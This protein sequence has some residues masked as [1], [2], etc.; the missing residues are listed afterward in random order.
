MSPDLATL[1]REAERQA[2]LFARS[3]M[4][5]PDLLKLVRRERAILRLGKY[6][7]QGKGLIED[8]GPENRVYLLTSQQITPIVGKHS[9]GA[10]MPRSRSILLRQGNTS[11]VFQAERLLHELRHRQRYALLTR[12]QR[13]KPSRDLLN[14]EEAVAWHES[15]LLCLAL[16]P[17]LKKTLVLQMQAIQAG[18]NR[19]E[20]EIYA[21]FGAKTPEEQQIRAS[22]CLVFS[23]MYMADIGAQMKKGGQLTEEEQI[24]ATIRGLQA[25]DLLPK[26]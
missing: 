11:V 26:R 9:S 1:F 8:W 23:A 7:G 15:R 10:C 5:N 16:Y 2:E 18:S 4:G 24:Q 13:T 14:R 6:N 12:K 17:E 19:V 21:P 3:K 22:D 25:V 20:P